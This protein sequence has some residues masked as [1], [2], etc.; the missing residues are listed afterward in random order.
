MIKDAYFKF[1]ALYGKS[2]ATMDQM[3]DRYDAFR[4]NYI[5]IES[6]NTSVD[7][8]GRSP[9]FRLGVN[10]FSDMTEKEFVNERLSSGIKLPKRKTEKNGPKK[11]L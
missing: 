8:S 6:H 4:D 2:Y 5:K 3:Q 7:E 10:Q 9:P 11:A 1:V